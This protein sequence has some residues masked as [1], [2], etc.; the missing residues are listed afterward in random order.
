MEK[1]W[2][3][4]YEPHVPASLAYPDKT[5][6]Q[7]L[8]DVARR[9]PERPATIFFKAKLTYGQLNDLVNRCAAGLQRMGV[10]KG[11]RVAILIPN[12]PQYVIAYY[13]ILR[14]G[15]I[16]VPC[17]PLYVA[18]ELNYQLKDSGARVIFTLSKFYNTVK[19]AQPGTPLEQ[20]VVTNIKEYFPPVLRI[21][22]TIAKEAKEG[23]R[24]DISKD[25]SARWLPY[26][27]ATAPGMPKGVE[28][29][30][31]DT[32]VLLY[33]GGTT[34]V[35]KAAELSHRN[36]MVNA[37]QTGVWFGAKEGEETILA[38]LP[39]SH[40][41][42]MTTAMNFPVYAGATMLLI[43][44]PRDIHDVLENIQR[45][46]PTAYPGVPTMY[47]AINNH[48]KV[49][50]YNLSSIKACISGGAPLPVEVQK[51][52]QEITGAR[53]VEGYGLSET[54]PVTHANPIYGENRIGTIGLPWPDTEARIV[55]VETGTR[56]MPVGETGELA[57]RGPQVMKGY[58]NRPDETALVLREGWLYTGDIAR[59]DAD[60]YFQ[61]VDRKKDMIIAGGFN[62]YPRDIEEV[63]YE[64]P[65]IKEAVAVGLPDPHRGETVKVYVVLKEGET[66]TEEEIIEYCRGKMARFKVPT[67]V[68]FRPE[69][70]KTMVGK[71]LRRVLREEE[72][73]RQAKAG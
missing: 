53:L 31:D 35:P 44:N 33:T 72:L 46:K 52:F 41:Y 59:M 56:E 30:L 14:I 61:I 48:P 12:S 26:F 64:H 69:L 43:A 55:D 34:G 4:K 67:A 11:D 22:F 66:A 71:I 45:F 18:R 3:S 42:G 10:R 51:R 17:N 6:P 68:E 28:I 65:K 57:I 60:G 19:E 8:A 50:E 7:L 38:A 9:F 16:A 47:V 54:S 27:L 13:G 15:A 32:A 23:H 39:L 62:I 63:L 5:L 2:L 25:A 40:S 20:I 36:I 29:G 70:P 49:S 1:P 73:A 21:L 24:V 37:V 58:W